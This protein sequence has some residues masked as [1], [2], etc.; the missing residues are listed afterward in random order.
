MDHLR[1]ASL[2]SKRGDIQRRLS[3]EFYT[4]EPICRALVQSVLEVG[5][6]FRS[7][8]DPFCGDGR[9]IVTWLKE[10]GQFHPLALRELKRIVLWDLHPDS[11]RSAAENVSAAMKAIGLNSGCTLISEACDTFKRPPAP[12]ESFDLILTN[13]PW[14]LLKPDSRDAIDDETNSA[15]KEA[16]RRYSNEISE[17]YPAAVSNRT[18]SM[19]GYDVNLARAGMLACLRLSAK[20]GAIGIVLPASLF[21]DQASSPFRTEVFSNLHARR[22]DYF[23]AESRAFSGVDQP[24]VT[25]V[26]VTGSPSNEFCLSRRDE[27]LCVREQRSIRVNPLSPEP[28]PFVLGAAQVEI[29]S[30]LQGSNP[31][32]RMLE[33]DMRFGLWLG[34]ELDETRISDC[35]G[36]TGV[37]FLKGRQVL[38]FSIKQHD[39]PFINP[40]K[41]SI[42]RSVG[43][44]RLAWRD[45]SRPNQQRRVHAS[46]IPRGWVT[47]NSLGVGYFRYGE[48]SNLLVLLAVL[49]S[50]VFELQVRARLHTPHVS[51]GALRECA[52]P[53]RA[54]EDPELRERVASAVRNCVLAPDS[55]DACV[56]LEVLVAKAYNVSL[57]QMAEILDAFPKVSILERDTLLSRSNWEPSLRRTS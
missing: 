9:L 44:V 52:V 43:E 54:F 2:A 12:N 3:G 30:W 56:N 20:S 47:G 35:F 17:S 57:E 24:F 5:A 8:S 36:E 10:M 1:I 11:V 55:L 28:I 40:Q 39:P 18:K 25:V 6:I 31:I 7:I 34:R 21:A 16:I 37:P 27:Q 51:L 48:A 38:R 15:Y 41:K 33:C 23:P 46:L 4:P 53:F 42:P 50:Y 22:I 19:A 49:N 13:P 14:D 32:L 45:V 26:G 29:T